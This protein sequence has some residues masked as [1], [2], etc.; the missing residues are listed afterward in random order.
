MGRLTAPLG[1]SG[2]GGGRGTL[3][4][5]D[6]L[7]PVPCRQRRWRRPRL[8]SGDR[9]GEPIPQS[10]QCEA[11]TRMAEWDPHMFGSDQHSGTRTG[12]DFQRPSHYPFRFGPRSRPVLSGLHVDTAHRTST[13]RQHPPRPQTLTEIA[14]QGAPT[15]TYPRIA[16]CCHPEVCLFSYTFVQLL[17]KLGRTP[18]GTILCGQYPHQKCL[19]ICFQHFS[20]CRQYSSTSTLFHVL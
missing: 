10:S 7:A 4:L 9:T 17:D 3:L 20:P 14:T 11:G 6:E 19:P 2:V 8:A 12:A 1:P 5:K 16:I 13:R 18:V 15:P